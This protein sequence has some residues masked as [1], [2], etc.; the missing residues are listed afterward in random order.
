MRFLR[1]YLGLG[2]GRDLE[3]AGWMLAALV[4]SFLAYVARV[5]EVTHDVF[6]EMSLFRH[7]LAESFPRHDVFA[8]TPTVTPSVH[9]EWGTGAVLYLFTMESGFGIYGL[10]I[11]RLMLMVIMWS[12]IYRVARL[13][14][15]HPYVIA[16]IA[17]A[18]FPVFWVGFSMVRAQQFTLTFLALQMWMQ[19]LDC[20]G[21]KF[22]AI[23][24][25]L[26]LVVWLN[27]HAGFIV[28]IAMLSVHTVERF[29]LTL[30]RSR[31][32]LGTLTRVWH[33]MLL[34]AAIPLAL[35][36]NPYGW[37]Y[38]PY[39]WDAITMERPLIREWQPIW[40]TYAPWIAVPSFALS[41]FLF[42]Y[43]QRHTRVS[44]MRGATFLAL[45]AYETV[46]HIRHGS[47]YGLLWLA[48]VPG[49][50]SRT[51][52]GRTIVTNIDRNRLISL[53]ICQ[54]I[55]IGTLF[56]ACM[57]QFW[58]PTMPT[59]PDRTIACFPASAIQFLKASGF[60]GNLLTPFQHG[61]F[62]SWMLHP[63]VRVSLDGRYEVAFQS[64][65]MEDHHRLYE[66]D[67][68]WAALLEKYP[69][70]AVLVEQCSKLRPLLNVFDYGDNG[71]PLPTIHSWQIVY[72]DD[73]FAILAR[74][75]CNLSAVDHRGQKMADCGDQA[76]D[77]GQ[78]FRRY[79][80]PLAYSNR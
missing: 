72:Q 50:L 53:R 17:I 12:A 8:F 41:L 54:A 4:C 63:A 64:P 16:T 35:P 32:I 7:S 25:W 51:A 14:G 34:W 20:R 42:A 1:S 79:V 48:Y 59:S 23:A 30:M 45:A 44:R 49:W 36:L 60:H 43:C 31:S 46:K 24:W 19:E 67:P 69:C 71:Q 5:Q 70:Q 28:G 73:A 76:F 38:L 11:L 80:N 56:F 10:S 27:M 18:A 75:E 29:I 77:R 74:R 6:H 61:A 9:H 57:N 15:A 22:W 55:T 26:M 40:F 3:L 52:M 58:K 65:V 68:E 33:L 39:L 66:G 37:S 78:S 13:R 2:A 47:L 62:V 21:R